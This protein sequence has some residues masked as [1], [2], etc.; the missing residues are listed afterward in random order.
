MEDEKMWT[1]E[2]RAVQ[3]LLCTLSDRYSSGACPLNSVAS[4][5]AGG[6]VGKSRLDVLSLVSRAL[7]LFLLEAMCVE[8]G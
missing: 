3:S 4:A 6:G 2:C 7:V 8:K 1:W 5:M